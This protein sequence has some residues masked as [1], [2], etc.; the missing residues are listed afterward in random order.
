MNNI[1]ISEI[2]LIIFVLVD[3]RYQEYAK[4]K[5]HNKLGQ[6]PEFSDGEVM[7]V[8]LGRWRAN[9]DKN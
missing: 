4:E 1:P 7:T 5:R 9:L 2:M 3:D 6:K 8:M